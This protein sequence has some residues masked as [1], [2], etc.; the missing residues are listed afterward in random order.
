MK[1]S[2]RFLLSRDDRSHERG[3]YVVAHALRNAGFEVILGGYQIPRE[4]VATAVQE[5]VDMIGVHIM[6]GAPKIIISTLF[7]KL[8]EKGI[9]DTPVVVGG[10]IPEKDEALIRELGVKDIFRPT[11]PLDNIVERIRKVIGE[12]H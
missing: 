4:I 2:I 10:I 7:N 9:E 5:D 12:D 3:C 6:Q 8:K 1:R 11:T